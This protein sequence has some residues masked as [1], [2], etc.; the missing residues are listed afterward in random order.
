[1]RVLLLVF[2]SLVVLAV[3][4]AIPLF[5]WL[6]LAAGP[7]EDECSTST[8]AQRVPDHAA[9]DRLQHPLRGL[10]GV[11][12][13]K[14]E[15]DPATRLAHVERVKLWVTFAADA[16][17][18]QVL[19][20]V[21]LAVEGLRS[22]EFAGIDVHVA[23]AFDPA[24]PAS[25]DDAAGYHVFGLLPTEDVL[26]DAGS[27]LDLHSRH[28]GT[29]V[30]L[31]RD[32]DAGLGRKVELPV[33]WNGDPALIVAAFADVRT[34]RLSGRDWE[35]ATVRTV[36]APGQA[37]HSTELEFTVVDEMLDGDIDI[38][39]M[40]S[41]VQRPSSMSPT[42]ELEATVTW[43]PSRGDHSPYLEVSVEF[44]LE[45]LRH[46][47]VSDVLDPGSRAPEVAA[48]FA[49]QVE[50]TGQ[51]YRLDI[52]LWNTQILREQSWWSFR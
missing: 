36:G 51:P 10:P 45:E 9:A 8:I 31:C 34:L 7:Q 25:E 37:G 24:A 22:Q 19:A 26:A 40:L 15:F 3:I 41:A 11:I 44:G 2:V 38:R 43:F 12:G 23:F 1:M 46:M 20:A 39:L 48:V 52:S 16:G 42:D 33:A 21:S 29:R 4:V 14:V 47:P 28:P 27:W 6:F 13:T 17:R 35:R 18:D 32:L 5:A 50:A 49:A 30:E